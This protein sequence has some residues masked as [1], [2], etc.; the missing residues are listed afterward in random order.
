[1]ST[2]RITL[3]LGFATAVAVGLALP[4]ILS[5]GSQPAEANTVTPELSIAGKNRNCDTNPNTGKPDTCRLPLGG[6]LTVE[7]YIDKIAGLHDSDGDTIA[8]YGG[9]GLRLLTSPA[10]SLNN[11]PQQTEL[12]PAAAPYWP[13]C[14]IRAESKVSPTNYQAGCGLGIGLFGSIHL[15]KVAE[16]DYTCTTL[17]VFSVTL[18][19]GPPP[20]SFLDGES[21]YV[22]DGNELDILTID[23]AFIWDVTGDGWVSVGD[24][25]RV[26][27]FFGQTVPPVAIEFDVTGD[28]TINVGD[29]GE[30]VAHFGEQ[31]PP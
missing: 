28:A 6:Q 13:D 2:A 30:V 23:C 5:W 22:P 18:P 31:A 7:V 10:L 20:D 15:G 21:Y 8:G 14:G 24:I 11:R 16:V 9:I 25:G 12:G 4:L 3:T 29:I 26:V 1:M 27:H 17:G 19:N